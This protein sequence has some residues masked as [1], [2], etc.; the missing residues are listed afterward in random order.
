MIFLTLTPPYRHNANIFNLEFGHENF[1]LTVPAP[2]L[3]EVPPFVLSP[4]FK[5][6]FLA[7]LLFQNQNFPAPPLKSVWGEGVG[8][9]YVYSNHPAKLE[10]YL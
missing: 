8:A 1:T 10:G 5:N 7:P 9:I 6:F 3:K 4:P 2:L